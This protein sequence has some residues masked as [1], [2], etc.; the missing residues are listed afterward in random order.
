MSRPIHSKPLSL[1]KRVVIKQMTSHFV[2]A[3]VNITNF[4]LLVSIL[5]AKRDLRRGELCYICIAAPLR[6]TPL[7]QQIRPLGGN[8]RGL[9]ASFQHTEDHTQ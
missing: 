2:A 1:I 6:G 4:Y 5:A 3:D 8:S 7:Q 9:G